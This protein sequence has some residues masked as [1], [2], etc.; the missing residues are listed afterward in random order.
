M[1]KFN[2]YNVKPVVSLIETGDIEN[3]VYWTVKHRKT[4]SYKLACFVGQLTAL[5]MQN[6]NDS[7]TQLDRLCVYL[8]AINKLG[9]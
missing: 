2:K 6:N 1:I 4:K 9:E 8:D 3:A 5:Y 7:D